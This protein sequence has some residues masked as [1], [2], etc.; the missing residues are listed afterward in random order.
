MNDKVAMSFLAMQNIVQASTVPRYSEYAGVRAVD[1][2]S[3][4]SRDL[5]D[6]D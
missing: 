4:G 6:I 2:S 3:K 5:G 1:N